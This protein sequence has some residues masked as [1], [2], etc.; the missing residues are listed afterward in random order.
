MTAEPGEYGGANFDEEA[1][2]AVIDTW[3]EGLEPEE[4]FRGIVGLTA[5]D[6]RKYQEFLDTVEVEFEGITAAPDGEPGEDGAAD[7]PELNVQILLDAS[8]SMAAEVDGKIKMDLAKDAIADFAKNLP[9]HA[10]VSLR[11]YGHIGSS[12]AEGKEKSCA[13]TEEVYALGEYNEDNCTK[14]LEKFS[15]TGYTPLALAIEDAA[16]DMEKLKGND[17]RN[18]VYIVSDGKETCGGDPI[19]QAEAM[20]SSDIGAIVNIIGF[21]IEEAERDALEA[22]AEAGNGE[23]FHADTAKELKETFEE[24]RLALIKAWGEWIH[25]NVTSNYEQVS[26]YID[27]SYELSSEASDL[28]REEESRQKDLTRYME[29]T[30]EEV[31]AIG[32]RSLITDRSLDM[33]EY[34]R[35]EFLDI[36]QEAREEGL[37]IRQEVRE[38]GLEERQELRDMD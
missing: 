19:A 24:E 25:D 38:R 15:P 6:Y 32:I 1:V 34:I 20:H 37:E 5:G 22:I 14:S 33:R 27:P 18:I 35:M 29:E 30:M 26:E 28:S 4:Y 36:R 10:N 31:D 3:P 8:G 23:Y 2:K 13:T 21:D 7:M 12:Q 17:V 9:E 11:V 16:K